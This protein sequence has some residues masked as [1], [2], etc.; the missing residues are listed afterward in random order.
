M[1]ITDFTEAERE[2]LL[3]LLVLAMYADGHLASVEDKQVRRL[4]GALGAES[5]YERNRQFDGSITRLRTHLQTAAAALEQARLLAQCFD[6]PEHRREVFTAL[7]ELMASDNSV[8][9]AESRF[10]QAVKEV[11]E[12]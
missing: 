2:A 3:D 1:N 11:F 10:L 12:A 9:H 7:T 5:T 6:P 8:T 4:L